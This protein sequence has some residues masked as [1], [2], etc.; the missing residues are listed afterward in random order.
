MPPR[1]HL[2]LFFISVAIAAITIFSVILGYPPILSSTLSNPATVLGKTGLRSSS[3]GDFPDQEDSAPSI[4]LRRVDVVEQPSESEPESIDVNGREAVSGNNEQNIKPYSLDDIL[5]VAKAYRNQFAVFAYI[6]TEDQFICLESEANGLFFGQKNTHQIRHAKMIIYSLSVFL[7]ALFPQHLNKD[8]TEF[9]LALSAGD[10]PLIHY[11]R[12]RKNELVCDSSVP[13]LQ[14][15]SVLRD[16]SEFLPNRLAMPV[17]QSNHLG[18]FIHWI[19]HGDVCKP[20]L[21][22][23]PTNQVG[24]VFG[25]TVS[26]TWEDLIPQVVWRGT[27]HAFLEALLSPRL[28][29]PN[30][31]KDVAREMSDISDNMTVALDGMRKVYDELVPRWKGVVWTVEAESEAMHKSGSLPW[32]D[33]KFSSV[34]Q[35]GV[36]NDTAYY[37]QFKNYGISAVGNKMS[38]E[39]LAKYKYHIDIGGGGGTTWSGTLEKLALPGLLFHHE[40]ETRDTTTISWSLSDPIISLFSPDVHFVPVKQDLSDLKEKYDWA[41]QNPEKAKE[42]SERAT[43][44]IKSFG[45]TEGMESLFKEY[46]EE[47][48]NKVISAYQPVDGSFQEV[49]EQFSAAADF[50]ISSSCTSDGCNT[51]MALEKRTANN[52]TNTAN[53]TT[54]I[55][56]Q[57]PSPRSVHPSCFGL[58]NAISNNITVLP[59]SPKYL[60]FYP[61]M[62]MGNN[63]MGYAS[64]VM[65]ACLSGRV[66]KIAPQ[67]VRDKSVF[68]EVFECGEFFAS[69]P[70]SICDGLEMDGEL[71]QKYYA[72]NV[73]IL[74]PEAYGDPPCGGNRL[75]DLKYFLC[76][77]ATPYRDIVQAKLRP[78]VKVQEKMIQKDG[79]FHVC[80]HVRM[81]E[82]KTR[83]TLGKDWLGDLSK[84]VSNLMLDHT[85]AA[86]NEILL[87]TMHADI[88]RDVKGTLEA[89]GANYVQ[90]ASETSP[91][92]P[93]GN[94]DDLHQG[95]ADM[96]TMATKC[97]NIL[98]SKADST[99]VLLSAN[100]MNE[101]RVFPGNQW[102]QGC[103]PGSEVV[104]FEPTGDFW[105]RRDL[106]GIRNIT[107]DTSKEIWKE[108]SSLL[109][110]S[111]PSLSS[112]QEKFSTLQETSIIDASIERQAKGLHKNSL[113]SK[114]NEGARMVMS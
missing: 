49:L 15:S 37:E 36:K 39:E 92:G 89:G 99:Y 107:C 101:T 11:D 27:D 1:L 103:M 14:F 82:E 53:T 74:G 35:R 22:R 75:Q 25:E 90:F 69:S 8:S 29:R 111:S 43:A 32:A 113:G 108:G 50:H 41:E 40:T 55:V 112:Y 64:A 93:Q 114:K 96:F 6:P 10:S 57:S 44:L 24:L 94:S 26:L 73:T 77:D 46:I 105:S 28:R 61:K 51:S 81:D 9:V 98:A 110:V 68:K 45:T 97:T 67:K 91:E 42:I 84:C 23:S 52:A 106:C 78:S 65:Y 48:L 38:L 58:G 34:M 71:V 102:K 63:I 21:P 12:C 72:A 2:H 16:A 60:I 30:F 85:A 18:C 17:P 88:R 66:L 83:N 20:F 59:A 4:D 79:P 86:S 104:D 87:F 80:V 109:P 56:I 5:P 62:G 54:D 31:E 95:V 33:M 3:F 7:R 76:N 47:P 70:G 100:L 13:V 19:E